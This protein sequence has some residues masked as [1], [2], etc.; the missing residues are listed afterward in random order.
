[1]M[2]LD[3]VGQ[4]AKDEWLATSMDSLPSK[5]SECPALRLFVQVWMCSFVLLYTNLADGF[6]VQAGSTRSGLPMSSLLSRT[7]GE[8]PSRRSASRLTA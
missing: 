4:E 5:V 3:R 7:I 6:L 8:A 2:Q 1:M